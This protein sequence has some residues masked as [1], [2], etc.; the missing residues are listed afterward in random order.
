MN[1]KIKTR[2][3]FAVYCL[4][5]ALGITFIVI[6][7]S[8]IELDKI[9]VNIGIN[10]ISGSVIFFVLHFFLIGDSDSLLNAFAKKSKEISLE[11]ISQLGLYKYE[12]NF[13]H[14]LLELERNRLKP[15]TYRKK[16]FES[17]LRNH[18]K[19][20]EEKQP[21]GLFEK[22]RVNHF[23]NLMSI[24]DNPHTLKKL[25]DI[26]CCFI[27]ENV[28]KNNIKFN[29][30]A[31]PKAGN[32]ALALSVAL[33]LDMPFVF[34]NTQTNPY[35][36][37][38][39]DGTVKEGD[40]VLFIN[41]VVASGHLPAKCIDVLRDSLAEVVGVYCL[42]ERTDKDHKDDITATDYL[43]KN[44]IELHSFMRLDDKKIETLIE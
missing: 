27:V 5:L 2:L 17:I 37:Q 10:L 16:T 39:I 31:S 41:D 26:F 14:L 42:I 22:T 28:N 12:G 25:S 30:I 19:S 11:T 20:F 21:I 38:E 15:T 3:S 8:S 7:F 32:S 29:K 23:I 18:I 35:K 40:K 6:N 13:N 24:S 4:I 33:Q 44:K 9:F 1:K 34:V 36:K 43:K